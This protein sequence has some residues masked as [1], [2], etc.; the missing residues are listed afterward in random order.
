MSRSPKESHFSIAL[1]MFFTKLSTAKPTWYSVKPLTCDVPSLPSLLG[2]DYKNMILLFYFAGLAGSGGKVFSAD[3]FNTFISQNN[4]GHALECTH[5]RLKGSKG[6]YVCIGN[7]QLEMCNAP[8]KGPTISFRI[9]NIKRLRHELMASVTATACIGNQELETMRKNTPGKSRTANEEKEEEEEIVERV[10]EDPFDDLLHVRIR[11][12]LLPLLIHED[13]LVSMTDVWNPNHTAKQV[14]DVLFD[15][16]REI[17]RD[18]EAKVTSILGSIQAMHSPNTKEDWR[19]FPVMK[20]YNIPLEEVRVH[21]SLVKELYRM[22]KK[23][24]ETNTIFVDL[25]DNKKSALLLIPL[26]DGYKRLKINEKKTKWFTTLMGALGGLGNEASTA[27][28]LFI[29]VS[30]IEEYKDAIEE[31]VQ[32]SGIQTF[33]N[34]D[35][36]ATFAMQSAANMNELQLRTLRRCCKAECGDYLFSSPYSIKRVLDLE[37][38]EPMTGTYKNGSE[39]IQ[40]MYKSVQEIVRLYFS[41][42]FRESNGAVRV[43]HIDLSFCIDHGKGYSRATLIIVHRYRND[44][45]EWD[46]KQAT[47]SVANARC[48]KDNAHIVKNTYG[49][50]LNDA[51]KAIRTIGCI[52]FFKAASDSWADS[53]AI[54]GDDQS[55]QDEGD[56][57]MS[58]TNVELWMAGDLLWYSTALGKEGY[59]GW[60]C[61][62]CTLF[63]SNWQ[64]KD[65]EVGENWTVDKLTTHAG[66]LESGELN[67]R[68]VMERQG[69]KEVPLFDAVDVD[70]YIMPVLHLTIGLVNDILDHLVEEMQAAGEWYTDDYYR[71][72]EEVIQADRELHLA[73][74]ALLTYVADHKEYEK[75]CRR[76]LRTARGE[77]RLIIETDLEEVCEEKQ[78]LQNEVDKWKVEKEDAEKA[79][80]IE[81]AKPEN[82]KEFGQPVRAFVDEVMKGHGIDRGAHFGG[83]LEGNSCRKLMGVAVDLVDRIEE[84]VLALPVEQRVV[85]IDDDIR[86]VITRHRELLLSFDGLMSIL[87]TVRFHVTPQL[88]I[89]AELYLQRFLELWR[90]L[91]LSVTPKLHCLEDHVIYFFRKYCGFCDLGEDSGEQAHQLEARSDKRLSAV[92]DFAKREKSKSKQ[93]VMQSQPQVQAKQE[94]M[95]RKGRLKEDDNRVVTAKNNRET[96]KRMRVENRET[97]LALPMPAGRLISLKKR[98]ILKLAAG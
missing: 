44:A 11:S 30:R 42:L 20:Q 4:L 59:A 27:R 18:R 98:R 70:H 68:I 48:K 81:K 39:K 73:A 66:K 23:V 35:A 89:K 12:H 6:Y 51:M 28:D 38:V 17:Q 76:R 29:H 71:L 16:V 96:K 25:G 47:F 82:G 55:K 93:E 26:S 85:G 79:L 60:W 94:E 45:N 87:R 50:H 10:V 67:G 5:Y 46:Q 43:D 84:H 54:I 90:H 40:W 14:E 86:E 19:Q 69:V 31:G 83:K 58:I 53:Y 88:I 9:H 21:A 24:N 13:K 63:K 15:I 34:F 78:A 92:R 3:K 7:R 32:H 91:G 22:N 97:V 56:E 33:P 80:K 36:V 57:C 74:G 72:E 49:T 65:H 41:T 64:S 2:M 95:M 8:G 77:A 61:P 52:S 37:Y 75:E 1:A 62:Y